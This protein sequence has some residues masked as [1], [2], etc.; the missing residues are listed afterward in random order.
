MF[1]LVWFWFEQKS[2]RTK[3]KDII[4][5]LGN[6]VRRMIQ[7]VVL[8]SLKPILTYTSQK[9]NYRITNIHN[10]T[11][12]SQS[13]PLDLVCAIYSHISF[14][15]EKKTRFKGMKGSPGILQLPWTR[16][17]ASAPWT[18]QLSLACTIIGFLFPWRIDCSNLR[19]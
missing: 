15:L 1:C 11:K 18:L 17:A 5:S 10:Q 14:F 2:F 13:Y 16:S 4:S 12:V 19:L 6:L 3:V 9:T 7:Y 8:S